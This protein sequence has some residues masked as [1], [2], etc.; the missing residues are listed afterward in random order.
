MQVYK[1]IL[2]NIKDL[3]N[4]SQYHFEKVFLSPEDLLKKVIIAVTD[5]GNE[6]G[7]QLPEKQLKD[8]DIIFNDNHN[9]IYIS[10]QT[11]DVLII[12]PKTINEMG[13]V[14]HNLGNRHMPAQFHGDEMFVPYDYLVEEYLVQQNI[15]F[16]RKD[17]KLETAFRH[18][19]GA[20]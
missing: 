7:I 16:E 17:V 8:G 3:K 4:A 20:H 15:P 5:H 6:I 14:A 11:T 10:L 19:D 12:K 2:S 13:V 18:V 9:I 1:E